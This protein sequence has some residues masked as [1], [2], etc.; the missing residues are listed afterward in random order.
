MI[1]ALKSVVL[2]LPSLYRCHKSFIL[3]SLDLHAHD[4]DIELLGMWSS[5]S[6]SNNV[7]TWNYMPAYIVILKF[8]QWKR[9]NYL[10]SFFDNN[11]LL[12]SLEVCESDVD[13]GRDSCCCWESAG[14]V[15]WINIRNWILSENW[16]NNISLYLI[17][18]PHT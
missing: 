5:C 1:E 11:L 10:H 3:T 4:I 18:V 17:L 9:A 6:F 7:T 12:Y 15:P 8:Y 16:K 14:T 2:I 13:G